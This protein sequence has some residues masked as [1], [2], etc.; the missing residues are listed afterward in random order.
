MGD[1][2]AK[3]IEVGWVLCFPKLLNSQKDLPPLRCKRA[4][5]SCPDGCSLSEGGYGHPI[6]VIGVGTLPDLRIE[7]SFV[8]V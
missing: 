8:Q 5:S 6:T 7:I 2:V 1:F 3:D 4:G